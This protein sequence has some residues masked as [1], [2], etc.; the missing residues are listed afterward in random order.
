M[1]RDGRRMIN[2]QLPGACP[3]AAIRYRPTTS[4]PSDFFAAKRVTRTSR[5]DEKIVSMRSTVWQRRYG[6]AEC[7]TDGGR[8]MLTCAL[9]ETVLWRRRRTTGRSAVPGARP[10]PV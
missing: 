8:S 6:M 4:A 1:A 10:A 9:V 3:P 5:L 2:S 7:K